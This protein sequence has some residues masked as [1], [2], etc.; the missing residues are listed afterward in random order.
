[1]NARELEVCWHAS[2]SDETTSSFFKTLT[3]K[4]GKQVFKHNN[5][6]IYFN[7]HLGEWSL[8]GNLFWKGTKKPD[9]CNKWV[10]QSGSQSSHSLEIKFVKANLGGLFQSEE[11]TDLLFELRDGITIKAH[12]S[13][14]SNRCSV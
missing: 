6:Q 3:V 9:G 2:C 4:N 7:S 12:K 8:N 14:I 10:F 11:Y 5:D 1:M 13:V